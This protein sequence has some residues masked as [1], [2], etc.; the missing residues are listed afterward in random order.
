[1]AAFDDAG[2]EMIS[3]LGGTSEGDAWH[4]HKR[5]KAAS[6]ET[7]C[8]WFTPQRLSALP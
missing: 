1:M 2:Q 4:R 3:G 5:S 7:A 8:G 6:E